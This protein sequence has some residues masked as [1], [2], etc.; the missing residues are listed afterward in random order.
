[1]NNLPAIITLWSDFEINLAVAHIELGVNGYDWDA[2]KKEVYKTGVI[3]GVKSRKQYAPCNDPSDA[4]PII[5]TNGI[6]VMPFREGKPKAW[7][8][9][10]GLLSDKVGDKNLLRAAMIVY[11]M[12]KEV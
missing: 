4:W 1:M 3:D 9:S 5:V 7:D 11:L 6:G 10:K 12:M 2:I 8:L